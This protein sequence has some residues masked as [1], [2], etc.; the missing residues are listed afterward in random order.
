MSQ[1][2]SCRAS[3]SRLDTVRQV[4]RQVKNEDR[5]PIIVRNAYDPNIPIRVI[6]S[7]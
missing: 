4:K 5:F 3:D 1:F 2:R 7:L 6:V